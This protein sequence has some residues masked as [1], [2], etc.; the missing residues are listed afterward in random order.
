[1]NVVWGLFWFAVLFSL[2]ALPCL[3]NRLLFSTRRPVA[4]ACVVLPAV[5]A[6]LTVLVKIS[7]RHP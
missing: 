6:A 7:S 3:F 4:T 2:P 1:M 5:L